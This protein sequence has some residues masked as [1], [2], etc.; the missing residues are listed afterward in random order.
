MIIGYGQSDPVVRIGQGKELFDSVR[1]S[2]KEFV[3]IPDTGHADLYDFEETLKSIEDLF[4]E[5]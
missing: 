1:S 3:M 5:K 4:F 2:K